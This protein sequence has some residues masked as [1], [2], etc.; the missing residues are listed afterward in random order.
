MSPAFPLADSPWLSLPPASGGPAVE[1]SLRHVLLEAHTLGELVVS[2]P[3]QRP[4]VLRHSLLPVVVD[5]LGRPADEREWVRW[6]EAGRWS[7]EQRERLDV[8][9][10]E[11]AF[12]LFDPQRPFAQVPDLRTAKDETKGAGL[13]VAT[14]ATGNNVPLFAS[15]TEGDPPKLTPPQAAHWLLHAHCWDTAAIKSGA[16][17]DP[18]TKAGKTT[19]NP[20]GPLGQMGVTLPTGRTLY[21]TLLLNIPAGPPL[22]SDDLP[23]WKRPETATPQWQERLPAGLL[24]VWTWQSRRIRLIPEETDEGLRVIRVV[25]AAGDRMPHT[26]EFDP[27]TMWRLEPTGKP[28]AGTS[29]TGKIR[30][31]RRPLRMQPGKAAWRGLDALLAPERQAR[32]ASED[33]AGF[34]TSVLFDQAGAVRAD[35]GDD[36]PLRVELTGM[37]YGNQSAVV[38]DVMFDALPL[39]LA[40]LGGDTLAHAAVLEVAEQAEDLVRAVNRLSADLRRAMGAEP[41]PWDKSQRPGELLL[42]ALDPL[43]RRFLAGLRRAGEDL[44]AIEAGQLAWEQLARRRAWEVADRLLQSVPLAA[45]AGRTISQGE[46]RQDRTYRASLAEASFTNRCDEILHRATEDRR[47]AGRP[48]MPGDDDV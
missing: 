5:A 28:R 29:R 45:Y 14:E 20:T 32:D 15:R 9:L 41:I 39:P 2:S 42:H 1:H 19:G 12:D 23:Q 48:L 34:A 46:G 40:A 22:R 44:D 47:Q 4:A 33:T 16:V 6:F 30:P 7:D 24:E 27:H 11:Y 43:V 18:K 38:E 13:L 21:E 37:A 8:Y 3:T 10:D 35:L 31:P 36:Y 26:P 25:V 17:G